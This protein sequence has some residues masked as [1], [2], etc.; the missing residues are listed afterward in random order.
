MGTIEWLRDAGYIDCGKKCLFGY[1]D[2]VLTARGLEMLKSV[3]ESVQTKKPIGDR[4]VAL[5][6]EKSMALAMETAKTAISA[7]IGLLK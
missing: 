3:P 2:C 6:K 5:L 4:L 1:Q 7:G